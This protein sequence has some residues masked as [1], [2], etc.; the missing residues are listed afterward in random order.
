[1]RA[2]SALSMLFLVAALCAPTTFAAD[3]EQDGLQ[4]RALDDYMAAFGQMNQEELNVVEHL[5]ALASSNPQYGHSEALWQEA[6]D[7]WRQFII[8]D[9]DFRTAATPG[10]PAH[11]T[12]FFMCETAHIKTRMEQMHNYATELQKIR[13]SPGI[14]PPIA[15]VYNCKVTALELASASPH[16][17]CMIRAVA[18]RCN[19]GDSCLVRCLATGGAP[20][21]GGGC[22]H[23]CRR[24]GLRGTPWSAPE[25]AAECRK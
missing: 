25:S 2:H 12:N 16:D 4:K 3:I 1:M 7:H 19:E 17:A 15:P 14:S 6:Q 11:E 5:R 20:F 23:L 18:D 22:Y 13:N 9:C 10:E 8:K 24:Y 21:I